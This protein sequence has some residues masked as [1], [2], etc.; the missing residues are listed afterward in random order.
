MP[1]VPPALCQHSHASLARECWA[2]PCPDSSTLPIPLISALPPLPTQGMFY[3]GVLSCLGALLCSPARFPGNSLPVLQVNGIISAPWELTLVP[4]VGPGSARGM[5]KAF[6][7]MGNDL[8]LLDSHSRALCPS[9]GH[10]QGCKGAGWQQCPP[11]RKRARNGQEIP[12]LSQ[13]NAAVNP[14]VPVNPT[15]FLLHSWDPPSLPPSLLALLLLEV[16]CCRRGHCPGHSF[17]KT[18]GKGAL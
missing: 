11:H 6:P 3:L 13:I 16:L 8:L 2:A 10:C 9:C 17:G 14:H 18:E 5:G 7:A 12:E 1:R 15:S 4:E